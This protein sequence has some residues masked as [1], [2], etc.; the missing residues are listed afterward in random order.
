MLWLRHR[1]LVRWD[2][3]KHGRLPNDRE[4]GPATDAVYTLYH[5]GRAFPEG[6]PF[7]RGLRMDLGEHMWDHAEDFLEYLDLARTYP[8]ARQ[9]L[10]QMWDAYWLREKESL[11][12]NPPGNPPRKFDLP[13]AEILLAKAKRLVA[14]ECSLFT[15]ENAQQMEKWGPYFTWARRLTAEDCVVTFNYDRVLE[16]LA[17]DNNTKLSTESVVAGQ[18]HSDRVQA[19]KCAEII[20]LHGSVDWTFTKGSRPPAEFEN[21]R[22]PLEFVRGKPDDALTCAADAIAIA[23]PGPTKA[24]LASG[25][26][27]PLWTRARNKIKDADAIVFVGYRFPPTDAMAREQILDAIETNTRPHIDLHVVL[28]PQDAPDVARLEEMLKHV[29]RNAKRQDTPPGFNGG[30]AFRVVRHRL[31]SQ[32]FLQLVT[33]SDLIWKDIANP[34]WLAKPPPQD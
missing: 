10:E 27:G 28:G 26:F 1:E 25:R 30:K 4:F 3:K 18:Y 11:R 14:A 16:I 34:R 31:W 2:E 32:D 7:K 13:S 17:D 19:S 12:W 15:F 23:T 29:G 21:Y 9:R 33:R 20:K 22:V 6:H 8:E 5:C 24:E